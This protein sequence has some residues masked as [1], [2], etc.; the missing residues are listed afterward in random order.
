M[1]N[2]FFD[3]STVHR[4][5]LNYA[6]QSFIHKGTTTHITWTV[7]VLWSIIL[8]VGETIQ[9]W[10]INSYP[11]VICTGRL[12]LWLGT[13]N[14]LAHVKISSMTIASLAQPCPTGRTNSNYICD[15]DKIFF[16]HSPIALTI[17]PQQPIQDTT[18]YFPFHKRIASNNVNF[19][20]DFSFF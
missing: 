3:L 15:N 14:Q 12:C 19:F 10:S 8:I 9:R 18:F 1:K 17:Y 13:G 11:S 7:H 5:K 2:Y 4:K 20:K 6:K 16:L